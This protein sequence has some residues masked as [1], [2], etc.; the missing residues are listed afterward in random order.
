MSET[1]DTA[2]IYAHFVCKDLIWQFRDLLHS[3]QVNF[4]FHETLEKLLHSRAGDT[5]ESRIEALCEDWD[6]TTTSE[7]RSFAMV[8][9]FTHLALQCMDYPCQTQA[10]D[11]CMTIAQRHA[12]FLIATDHDNINTRPCLQWMIAKNIR[13]IYGPGAHALEYFDHGNYEPAI[14]FEPKPMQFPFDHFKLCV[15]QRDS[16]PPWQPRGRCLSA[17]MKHTT[18]VVLEAAEKLGDIA[19]QTACWRQAVYQ[20]PELA[21]DATKRIIEISKDSGRNLERIETTLFQCILVQNQAEKSHLYDAV[22]ALTTL[23]DLTRSS[24]FYGRGIYTVL[25]SLAPSP[26]MKGVYATM[27]NEYEQKGVDR[28]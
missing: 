23:I 13:E 3:F 11:K 19:L 4:D 2:E 27:A 28:G 21:L 10:V 6:H 24:P 25:Q 22:I 7:A 16:V 8:E 5:V 17:K 18:R 15:T 1:I 14:V 20:E 26:Q 9:I 12:K